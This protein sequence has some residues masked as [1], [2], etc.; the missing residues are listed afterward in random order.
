[1]TGW[2]ERGAAADSRDDP[3]SDGIWRDGGGV[4]DRCDEVESASS[5]VAD[6]RLLEVRIEGVGLIV[7]SA[8]AIDSA[9]A[10][11]LG[12]FFF[13]LIVSPLLTDSTSFSVRALL[14]FLG[15]GNLFPRETD[16]SL[17][18]D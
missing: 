11:A 4:R 8:D 17:T 13:F 15:A 18:T 3:R 5:C 12:F 1:M 10:R 14:I 9:S 2:G 6:R 7:P 16:A